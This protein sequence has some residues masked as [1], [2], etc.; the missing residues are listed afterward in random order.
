MSVDSIHVILNTTKQH[1]AATA[2]RST[3]GIYERNELNNHYGK[4]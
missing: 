4:D 1:R 3:N 2:I